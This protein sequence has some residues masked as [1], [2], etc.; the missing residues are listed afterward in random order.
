MFEL[1]YMG[2]P[3]FMGILTI[4]LITT[5]VVAVLNGYKV[6]KG[7]YES[8]MAFRKIGYIK[9]LGLFGL[10]VGVLGQLIGLLGA[11]SAIEEAGNVSAAIVA[12]GL[13]ISMITTIYGFVIYLISYLNRQIPLCA[14]RCNT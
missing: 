7:D 9:S 5:L 10:V 1:F 13:K 14:V 11:F 6:L 4:I 12:G 3:L 8:D 2:G